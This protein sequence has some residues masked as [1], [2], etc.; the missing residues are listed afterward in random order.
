MET[1]VLLNT[2]YFESFKFSFFF[3]LFFMCRTFSS[4]SQ[5]E[6]MVSRIEH[7]KKLGCVHGQLDRL[8]EL[9]LPSISGMD[10]VTLN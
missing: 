10:L 5:S 2:W 9:G 7:P 8:L 1:L 4:I 6:K 3:F